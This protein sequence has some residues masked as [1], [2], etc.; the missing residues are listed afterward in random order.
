MD[1]YDI[2][3][4]ILL[5]LDINSIKNMCLT[6]SIAMLICTTPIFWHDKFAADGI[7][8]LTQHTSIKGWINEYKFSVGVNKSVS[9]IYWR[10]NMTRLFDIPTSIYVS[11]EKIRNISD[12]LIDEFDHDAVREMYFMSQKINSVACIKIILTVIKC[13]TVIF[14]LKPGVVLEYHL[15]DAAMKNLLY[16]LVYYGYTT[17]EGL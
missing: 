4:L 10:Y 12:I 14:Y 11:F 15:S 16:R 6:N 3:R 17:L 13:I 7:I 5:R 1:I 9:E 8:L 2:Q